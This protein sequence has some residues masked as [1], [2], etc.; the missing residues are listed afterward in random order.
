[1]DMGKTRWFACLLLFLLLV[2]MLPM[3]AFAK[4]PDVLAGNDG[5]NMATVYVGGEAMT[6]SDSAESWYT[7]SEAVTVEPASYSAHLYLDDDNGGAL[8]LELKSLTV[9]GKEDHAESKGAGI[10]TT[11][12]LTIRYSGENTVTAST[13]FDYNANPGTTFQSYDISYGIFANGLV[14]T[15]DAGASLSV[16]SADVKGSSYGIYSGGA[17][18][19]QGG[20][21]TSKSGDTIDIQADWTFSSVGIYAGGE[22]LLTDSASI[23][24]AGG[25]AYAGSYRDSRSAGIMSCGD[26]VIEGCFVEAISEQAF[27]V[28]ASV[29]PNAN[30]MRYSRGLYAQYG[31]ITITNSNVTAVGGDAYGDGKSVDSSVGV[32]SYGGN[33]TINSGTVN[34][35]GGDKGDDPSY[36]ICARQSSSGSTSDGILTINGGTVTAKGGDPRD[37]ADWSVGLYAYNGIAISRGTVTAEGGKGLVSIGIDCDWDLTVSNGAKVYA[38]ADE[39]RVY[40]YGIKVWN[41]YHQSGSAEVHATAANTIGNT[42]GIG[43]RAPRS[44]GFYMGDSYNEHAG[45]AN[46]FIITGGIFEAQS[47]ADTYSTTLPSV[48]TGGAGGEEHALKFFD[49][50]D[51][52]ATF[53]D[54]Q[55]PNAEWYWWTLDNGHAEGNKYISPT[56]AYIYD[57]E[58]DNYLSKY[59][60]IAP[61]EPELETGDLSLTKEVSGEGADTEREFSFTVTLSDHSISGTYGG[62]VFDEGVAAVKAKHGQTV[63]AAGLPAGITYTIVEM[64]AYQD[65]YTTSS[66]GATGTIRKDETAKAVFVNHKESVAADTQVSVEKI[67]KLDDGGTA[68]GS[69]TVALFRNDA[70]CSVVTLDESNS[71]Q[72]TWIGLDSQYRWTVQEIDV[73]NGFEATVDK[74]SDHHFRITN[75]DVPEESPEDPEPSA[76]DTPG[77][78]DSIQDPPAGDTSENPADGSIDTTEN[79]NTTD[80]PA[81]GDTSNHGLWFL[82]LLLSG[83]GIIGCVVYGTIK[84]KAQSCKGK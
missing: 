70:E 19:A 2:G 47:L 54:S 9:S 31:D 38:T 12:A 75:D 18:T 4:D 7:G 61:I 36:G 48:D 14:L 51:N 49:V 29:P 55:Q 25:N 3:I 58:E 82:L 30:Y 83:T 22:M 68:A 52:T 73:P 21:I 63:T 76:G 34:A 11:E 5:N 24:A 56:K 44:Y 28:D 10:Y 43:S 41:N 64:E 40:S 71:W 62:M 53:S 46:T 8:T 84:R 6:A 57:D 20:S 16:T 78:F 74:V 69:I 17:L 13:A 81:T 60:Y 67:W 42:G 80:V 26:M 59:L 35:A 39:A 50:R 27:D 77:D 23:Y 32:L 45:N 33:V 79:S 66:S 72:H 1:M 37:N 15:G 65:G